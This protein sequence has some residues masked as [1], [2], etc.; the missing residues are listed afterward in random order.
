MIQN[1]HFY[2]K[3]L[4]NL[5]RLTPES[6]F[7]TIINDLGSQPKSPKSQFVT[8]ILCDDYFHTDGTFKSNE[9]IL[10]KSSA[11]SIFFLPCQLFQMTCQLLKWLVNFFKW[12]VKCSACKQFLIWTLLF[13]F[14]DYQQLKKQYHRYENN[15]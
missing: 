7:V 15:M 5:V 8:I 2:H 11:L 9:I 3:N 6:Q 4:K 10:K 14:L 1:H 12:L 13:N